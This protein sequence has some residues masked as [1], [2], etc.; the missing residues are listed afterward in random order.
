M[1]EFWLSIGWFVLT[2]FVSV[3]VICAFKGFE[4]IQTDIF[5]PEDEE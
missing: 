2:C 4:P 3:L 5:E 1:S